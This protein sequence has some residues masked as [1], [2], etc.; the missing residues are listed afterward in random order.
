MRYRSCLAVLAFAAL[1]SAVPSVCGAAEPSSERR[2]MRIVFVS[3]KH[4]APGDAEAILN[5]LRND[6]QE[7]GSELVVVADEL[8]AHSA[9]SKWRRAA[10]L[11]EER[12]ARATF[13]LDESDH[14]ELLVCFF[15]PE[16]ERVVVRRLQQNSL[17]PSAIEE[18]ALLVRSTV[19]ALQEGKI[20][21]APAAGDDRAAPDQ[22]DARPHGESR[23]APPRARSLAPSEPQVNNVAHG[24][25]SPVGADVSIAYSG[26][27]FAPEV[28]Q[29][30]GELTLRLHLQREWYAAV[31][32]AAY[33]DLDVE[34][35]ATHITIRRGAL[36]FALGRF[37]TAGPFELAVDL[38][39]TADV[40]ER[41]TIATAPEL[42]PSA[43]A[44]RVM[45]VLGARAGLGWPVRT[46]WQLFVAAGPEFI[47]NPFVF[48]VRGQTSALLDPLDVRPRVSAGFTWRLF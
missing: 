30:G 42:R 31:A 19:I 39:A 18:I 2:Q 8:E 36:L 6:L 4:A 34:R 35:G 47:L 25:P 20:A 17:G 16:D 33:R 44:R 41:S 13:W 48:S 43:E 46:P 40:L 26:S 21:V 12:A 28:W 11:N 37:L 24:G 32:A 27:L 45:W 14:G 9:D 10:T 38:S 3:P 7:L 5:A 22:S 1:L 15:D 23:P 29:H